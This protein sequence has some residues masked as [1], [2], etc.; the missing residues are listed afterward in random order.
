MATGLFGTST[1]APQLQRTRLQPAGVSSAPTI[2]PQQVQ[3]GGNLRALADALGGLN[4]ALVDYARV[5]DKIKDDPASEANKEWIA[6]AGQMSKDDLIA[7]AASGEADG[8]RAREDALNSLLGERAYADF[9]PA[10]ETYFATEFDRSTG[11][12]AAEYDRRRQ[13]YA[14]ALPNDI[15]RANF[16]RLTET[17]KS[18]TI[19]GITDER[20]A[21]TKQQVN[22]TIVDGWYTKITE[23]GK[24]GTPISPQ[25]VADAVF[26]AST[27]NGAFYGLSGEEQ[28]ATIWA[29][30]QR[31]AADGKVD[32][33]QALLDTP[34]KGADGA[35]LPSLSTIPRY[36]VEGGSL[37]EKAKTARARAA[38]VGSADLQLSLDT[39]RDNGTLTMDDL[40][41]HIGTLYSEGEAAN[42][43]NASNRN[44]SR[45]TTEI[46]LQGAAQ[47]AE[48]AAISRVGELMRRPGGV[49]RVVD[50][51]VPTASGGTRTLSRVAQ[52]EAYR[53]RKEVEWASEVDTRVAA[54]EDEATVRAEVSDK[55][56]GW[57]ISQSIENEEW[58]NT[59][60]SLPQR[61]TPVA[62]DKNPQLAAKAAQDAELFLNL[63]AKS[64]AYADTLMTPEARDF[65]ETYAVAREIDRMT[66][67][68]A[69]SA[70][71]GWRSMP[72]IERAKVEMKSADRDS[73]VRKVL[74]T[75]GVNGERA[76]ASGASLRIINAQIDRM[77]ARGM[78][79]EAI[80]KRL[81]PWIAERTVTINGVMVPVQKGMP[82]EFQIVAEKHI[83]EVFEANKSYLESMGI[84]SINDLA[85]IPTQGESGWAVIDKFSGIPVPLGR[86]S[87]AKLSEL[88]KGRRGEIDAEI[89]ANLEAKEADAGKR[90]EA[91]E[92]RVRFYDEQIADRRRQGSK[93]QGWVADALEQEK[94]DY[95][96]S[97]NP[98]WV[99]AEQEASRKDTR[100]KARWFAKRNGFEDPFP[101]DGTLPPDPYAD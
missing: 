6:R 77:A 62:L 91:Y 99:K 63:S 11:D 8:H 26:D 9:I 86:L 39:R 67:E 93:Y 53:Q 30:A 97:N 5:D 27:S 12:T 49:D 34:R 82:W 29:L 22:T 44:R 48:G 47:R 90:R 78:A 101:E 96:N 31:L 58:A 54:G 80:E 94:Q 43:V 46:A 41:P 52:I 28:N 19:G 98:E 95:I 13:R 85:L 20:I 89:K 32:E 55:R 74:R 60:R 88:Q 25:E 70:A 59:F 42:M 4:S 36:S 92:A 37:I 38:Q 2:R 1:P 79:P 15:A 76:E 75:D 66:P 40:K 16:Y 18:R 57:Y 72:G 56:Q 61:I 73:L 7:L 68:E 21:T 69:V 51:E 10:T 81:K 65:L 3:T 24:D 23:A 35:S 64:P 71:A 33:A 50:V 14:D 87:Q 84:D 100:I 17:H 45:L 83:N